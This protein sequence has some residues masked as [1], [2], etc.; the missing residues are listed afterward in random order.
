MH[1][2]LL[3]KLYAPAGHVRHVVLLVAPTTL[4]YLPATHTVHA[5]LPDVVVYVPAGHVAHVDGSVALTIG[6]AVPPGHSVQDV[7]PSKL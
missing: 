7:L 1:D 5:L 3:A 2:E 6:E 4:E